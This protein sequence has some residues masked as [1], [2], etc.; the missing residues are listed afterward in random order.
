MANYK[1]IGGDLKQYGPVTDEEVRK[2]I[3]EGRLN[4]QS[5]VQVFGD[6]EWKKLSEFPE[7]AEA[8]AGKPETLSAPLPTEFPTNW[9][10]RDYSLDIGGCIS[11]GWELVKAEFLAEC[12]CHRPDHGDYCGHQSGF[13]P[14]HPPGR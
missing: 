11:R 1:I 14:V 3:A 4:S 6:I 9:Q 2:W 10:E 8:L 7:F 5:L 13:W 12:G